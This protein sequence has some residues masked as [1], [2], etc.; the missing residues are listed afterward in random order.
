MILKGIGEHSKY[1]PQGGANDCYVIGSRKLDRLTY[2]DREGFFTSGISLLS[3]YN[4]K[5]TDNNAIKL[6]ES[7]FL[8]TFGILPTPYACRGYDATMMFCTKMFSGLD[9]YILLERITPLGTTYQ[10]VF[11]N[12]MF[13]NT[14]WVNIQYMRDF[15]VTYK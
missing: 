10:F 11:D 5:R 3:P 9:K 4:S 14:E 12:G 8:Q 2:V 1:M 15:T 7:R 13:V 6:F